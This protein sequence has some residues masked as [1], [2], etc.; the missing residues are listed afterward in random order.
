MIFC[1]FVI[2]FKEFFVGSRIEC[3]NLMFATAKS[4]TCHC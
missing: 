1:H 4:Y 3:Q 2:D